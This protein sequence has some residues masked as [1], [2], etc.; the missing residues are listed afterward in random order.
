MPRHPLYRNLYIHP[1]TGVPLDRPEATLLGLRSGR[2]SS[3][4]GSRRSRR[5]ESVSS[6]AATVADIGNGPP[7]V[8]GTFARRRRRRRRPCVTAGMVAET[9]SEYGMQ[10]L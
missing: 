6:A 10:S 3:R 2:S 9:I 1:R 7:P 8:S 4:L 5:V